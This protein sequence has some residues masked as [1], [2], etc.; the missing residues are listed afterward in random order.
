[1][2]GQEAVRSVLSLLSNSQVFPHSCHTL[3]CKYP[4]LKNPLPF[5]ITQE[6][7]GPTLGQ[8]WGWSGCS[9]HTKLLV[10]SAVKSALQ[11]HQQPA[12]W[13]L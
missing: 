12:S 11:A 10:P 4:K 5:R 9:G 2:P 3:A 8:V 7:P 6:D 13:H 1:M